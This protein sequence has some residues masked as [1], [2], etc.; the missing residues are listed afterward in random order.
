MGGPEGTPQDTMIL[1]VG[2]PTTGPLFFGN[3]H[4]VP[5]GGWPGE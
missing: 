1:M 3:L 2:A 5:Q 4:L